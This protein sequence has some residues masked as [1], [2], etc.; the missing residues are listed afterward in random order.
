MASLESRGIKLYDAREVN[1]LRSIPVHEVMDS[2]PVLLKAST[3]FTQILTTLLSGKTHYAIVVTDSDGYIGTIELQDIREVL[4][5]SES[6]AALIIAQD[7]ANTHIPYILKKDNLDL[8]MH[9]FG[10]HD[11]DEIAVCNNNR[12]RKVI[13]VLTKTAVINAYNLRIF[14]EDLTGGFSS[15]LDTV[16]EGRTIEV[17]GDIHLAQ[18]DIP[19]SWIGKAINTLDLRRKHGLEIVLVYRKSGEQATSGR[20]GLFPSPELIL[21]PG[22]KLL[23]LSAL[24][25][26]KRI[27]R[28]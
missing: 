19:S 13:G 8:A 12:E 24:K 9:L 17:M 5:E 14:Q 2:Q 22:D 15:I 20:P 28:R 16:K 6:L 11:K 4:Q 21:R 26:I 27:A 10:R 18:I 25:Q 1:L 23:V 3:P 7:V